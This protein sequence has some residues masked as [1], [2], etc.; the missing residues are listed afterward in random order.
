MNVEDFVRDLDTLVKRLCEG[1]DEEKCRE[2]HRLRN[3]LVELR[4]RK[5]VNTAH[6]VMELIVAKY[7]ILRGYSV[8]VE[9]LLDSLSCDVYGVKGLGN[10]VVEI[11]TG[12]VPPSHSLDPYRYLRARIASKIARYSS[13]SSRF[14]IGIPRQYIMP[15]EE[16]FL[17]PPRRRRRS[18]IIRVK[19]LCDIYY[20]SP[21]VSMSE[22]KNARLHAVFVID[23][24]NISVNELDP[25]TYYEKYAGGIKP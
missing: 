15:L 12:Y 25:E 8:E 1:M 2:I 21:P 18:D 5:M 9:Y 10:A 19:E 4:E 22:I 3:R 11:E 7:L 20:S 13:Y 23:V 14:V 6:S 16:I 24:D 17:L